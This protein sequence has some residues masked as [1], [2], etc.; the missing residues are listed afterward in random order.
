MVSSGE[1]ES[2]FDGMPIEARFWF[3]LGKQHAEYE[4]ESA[5]SDLLRLYTSDEYISALNWKWLK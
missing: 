2:V 5:I 3:N 1:D 4:L